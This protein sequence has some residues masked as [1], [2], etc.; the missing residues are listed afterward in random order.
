VV[1]FDLPV[2]DRRLFSADRSHPPDPEYT[3]PFY[4]LR[5]QMIENG[6]DLACHLARVERILHHHE[7]VNVIWGWL[8]GYKGTKNGEPSQLSRAP[9]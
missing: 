6:C 7:D 8:R 2:F 9:C 4:I 1:P 5:C 3:G